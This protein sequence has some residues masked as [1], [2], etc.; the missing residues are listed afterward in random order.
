LVKKSIKK[1][2]EIVVEGGVREWT[3]DEFL[4]VGEIESFNK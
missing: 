4:R 3:N 1:K 2:R